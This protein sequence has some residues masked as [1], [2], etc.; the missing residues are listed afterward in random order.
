MGAFHA[1]VQKAIAGLCERLEVPDRF[2]AVALAHAAGLIHR[3]GP[4]W[5][6]AMALHLWRQVHPWAPGPRSEPPPSPGGD[7]GDRTLS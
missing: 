3:H 5:T 6:W 2:E 1:G 7:G 4:R